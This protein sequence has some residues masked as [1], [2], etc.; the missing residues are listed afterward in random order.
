MKHNILPS[1]FW[2]YFL[3]DLALN[4]LPDVS[5]IG[6]GSVVIFPQGSYSGTE[7]NNTGGKRYHQ[8]KITTIHEDTDGVKR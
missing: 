3:Q 8:G 4:I 2:K 5:E 6:V 1:I 7:G